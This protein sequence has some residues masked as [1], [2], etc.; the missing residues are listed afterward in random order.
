MKPPTAQMPNVVRNTMNRRFLIFFSLTFFTVLC[1]NCNSDKHNDSI[2]EGKS[3]QV[4]IDFS[5]N[6]HQINIIARVWGIAGNHEEITIL[7]GH[8]SNIN[9]SMAKQIFYT[10]EIFYKKD[11]NT[12]LVFAPFSSYNK[13][14]LQTIDNVKIEVHPL[15]TADDI[16]R[17]ND[18]YGKMGLKRVSV[19]D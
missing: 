2:L 8:E 19:Y 12:L 4:T 5:E 7:S 11:K 3:N 14:V 1:S 13:D 10:S 18:N 17:Y 6:G 9:D 15:Y 16:Q